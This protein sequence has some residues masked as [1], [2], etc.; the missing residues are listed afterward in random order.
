MNSHE[1]LPKNHFFLTPT[2]GAAPAR[3]KTR[4]ETG[5]EREKEER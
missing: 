4:I 3:K 2:A 5:K 1:E